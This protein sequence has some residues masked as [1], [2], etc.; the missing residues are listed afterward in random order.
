MR[1]DARQF[2]DG[3]TEWSSGT[4]FLRQIVLTKT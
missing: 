4:E 1:L 2:T 3:N